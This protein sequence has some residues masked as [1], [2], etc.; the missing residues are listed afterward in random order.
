MTANM[1]TPYNPEGMPHWTAKSLL[2][3]RLGR[4]MQ[5]AGR[6]YGAPFSREFRKVSIPAYAPDDL[7]ATMQHEQERVDSISPLAFVIFDEPPHGDCAGGVM[8]VNLLEGMRGGDVK[9]E[10]PFGNYIPDIGL[11]RKGASAPYI[12]IEVVHTNRP[13]KRKREFYKAQGIIAFEL[14]VDND[15]DIRGV[16]GRASVS[17]SSL[18]HAPC[19]GALREEVSRNDKYLFDKIKSGEHSFI[20]METYPSGTQ[21]YIRGTYDPIKDQHWSYGEPE[22]FG[23]C[24]TEARWNSPPRIAPIE[25]QSVSKPAFLMDML[26]GIERAAYFIHD[27]KTPSR[28]KHGWLTLGMYAQ[29]LLYSVHVPE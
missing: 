14:H 22:V 5:N 11:Y 24:P 29:D 12:V 20:G 21:A 10:E 16:V 17:V 2:A 23:W 1:G 6:A 7:K 19:G 13:S 27:E 3:H 8:M 25:E 15:S 4:G 26:M 18:S 28:N 9:C